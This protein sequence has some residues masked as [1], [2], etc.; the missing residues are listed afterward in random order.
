MSLHIG[1]SGRESDAEVTVDIDTTWCATCWKCD[2]FIFILA[3][4]NLIEGRL[5]ER[6]WFLADLDWKGCRVGINKHA[7][8]IALVC[9]EQ[10]LEV[11]TV[12]ACNN[13]TRKLV[14]HLK[15]NI[16]R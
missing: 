11:D 13:W 9:N 14:L 10:E 8:L 6:D 12:W 4:N 15:F 7:I 1:E 3:A 5:V 2:H 16:D